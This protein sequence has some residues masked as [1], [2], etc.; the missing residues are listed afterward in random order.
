[1]DAPLLV[2]R[3]EVQHDLGVA[4]VNLALDRLDGLQ[5][6]RRTVDAEAFAEGAHP[7]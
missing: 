3:D 6:H 5:V 1:V 2:R 7:Q 4:V